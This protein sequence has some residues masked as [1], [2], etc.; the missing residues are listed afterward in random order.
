[1]PSS[2]HKFIRTISAGIYSLPHYDVNLL[3]CLFLKEEEEEETQS[4]F[5]LQ[6]LDGSGAVAR[7]AGTTADDGLSPS[8]G[9]AEGTED[10]PALGAAPGRCGQAGRHRIRSGSGRRASASRVSGT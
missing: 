5:R 6:I 9:R 1:M 10:F 8:Q 7:P 2:K 4:G 3:N